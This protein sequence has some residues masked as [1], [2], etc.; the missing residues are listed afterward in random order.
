MSDN[1]GLPPL[2]AT[3]PDAVP[4][5]VDMPSIPTEFNA[6]PSSKDVMIGAG[7]LVFFAVI[8]FLVRNAYVNYLVGSQKRSPNN[9]GLAGWGLFGG[10]FFGAAIASIALISKTMLTVAYIAPLAVLSLICF[11]LCFVVGSKK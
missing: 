9:A 3:K 11:V 5:T 4:G 8:F 10:L 2:D 7:S 1:S 6:G